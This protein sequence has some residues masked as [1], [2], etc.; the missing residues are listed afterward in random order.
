V[1]RTI[2]NS[3]SPYDSFTTTAEPPPHHEIAIN[4][5]TTYRDQNRAA[6]R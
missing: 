4:L 3:A 6:Q 2:E 5:I 1:T